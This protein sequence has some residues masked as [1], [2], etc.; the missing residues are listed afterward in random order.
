ME[1]WKCFERSFQDFRKH[2][3][4]LPK[5]PIILQH[6]RALKTRTKTSKDRELQKKTFR[7]FREVS[8]FPKFFGKL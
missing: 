8:I 7:S 5:L 2:F 3:Q 1:A 6:P 4:K